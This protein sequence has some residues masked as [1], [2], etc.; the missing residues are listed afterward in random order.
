[1][2]KYRGPIQLHVQRDSSFDFN[3]THDLRQKL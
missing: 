3:T 1:M 2:R